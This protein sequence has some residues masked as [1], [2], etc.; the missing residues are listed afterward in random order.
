MQEEGVKKVK[1][2]QIMHDYLQKDS[3]GSSL[4]KGYLSTDNSQQKADFTFF[5]P[6]SCIF[7]GLA[8]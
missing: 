7:A 4:T 1:I 3:R 2:M 8:E 5:T 6:T